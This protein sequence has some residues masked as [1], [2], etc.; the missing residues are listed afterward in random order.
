MEAIAHRSK[1]RAAVVVTSGEDY[2]I[3]Q[4]L[5]FGL[6]DGVYAIGIR[7]ILGPYGVIN[8]VLVNLHLITWSQAVDWL[9]RGRFWAVAVTEALHLYPIFYLNA[10]AAIANVDPTLE[11]AAENLGCTGW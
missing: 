6:A 7:Q 9:G 10:V 3:H 2:D 5:T 1:D 4:Y 11:E 8:A